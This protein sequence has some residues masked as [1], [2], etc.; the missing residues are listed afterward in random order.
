M[1]TSAMTRTVLTFAFFAALIAG[2]AA[3]VLV[4]RSGESSSR[5]VEAL[6][7]PLPEDL[8]KVD[9][10]IVD[11]IREAES[12]VRS[13]PDRADA[14]L[15]LGMTYSASKLT[16]LAAQC[17]Q[18]AIN[19][20]AARPRIWYLLAYCE[21]NLGE[22]TRAIASLEQASILGPSYAPI[23]WRLGFLHLDTGNVDEADRAFTTATEIDPNDAAGWTGRARV[24]LERREYESAV[25]LLEDLRR[26]SPVNSWYLSGLLGRAYRALGQIDDAQEAL[27]QS[28]GDRPHWNDPWLDE[29]REFARGYRGQRQLADQLRQAGRV[30]EAIEVLESLRQDHP[31]RI[32]LTLDLAVLY[33]AADRLQESLDLLQQLIVANPDHARGNFHLAAT[34][35][36]IGFRP[37]GDSPQIWRERAMNRVDHAL[38]LDNSIVS[39][40]ALRADLL[41]AADRFPEA[42]V[43]Y[44]AAARLQ[45]G[46][47]KWWYRSGILN[48]V[49]HRIDDAEA[50]FLRV[51][52]IDPTYSDPFR[53]EIPSIDAALERVKTARQG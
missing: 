51:K 41:L 1:V 35:A 25:A 43:E 12:A 8:A 30:A 42:V 39:A 36:K 15:T 13:D 26:R 48:L 22:F 16:D 2:I 24:H 10:A 18:Q 6:V 7:I 17:Y 31:D 3:I 49:L 23:F 5:T 20:D 9:P 21:T 29:I 4:R 47:P 37:G 33:R 28:R 19:R 34:C 11:L 38:S 46:E 45:P 14:W 50:D 52:V 27:R 40:H 32:S 53:Q 44:G